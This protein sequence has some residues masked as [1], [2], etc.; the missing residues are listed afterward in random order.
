MKF[1]KILAAGA[2][3]AA[4]VAFAQAERTDPNAIA[5]GDLM[6]LQGKN[7][8]VLGGMASGKAA[9]DAAAAEAAKAVLLETSSKI[10][11]TFMEPGEPDPASLAKPEIWTNWDDFVV[12][13]TALNTA[14]AAL[15]VSSV[16]T[17]GAGMA[18]IGGACGGCHEVYRVAKE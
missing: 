2:I 15:D 10:P 17:I 5:R 6:K 16:E 4:G 1:A 8:G 13:A 14:V 11:E 7:A 3:L 12:K 18:A 9:Y